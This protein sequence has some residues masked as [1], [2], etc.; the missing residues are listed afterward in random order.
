MIVK[1]IRAMK[2]ET[3]MALAKITDQQLADLINRDRTTILRLRSGKTVAPDW[4]TV[5]AIQDAT[6]GAV[7]PDDWAEAVRLSKSDSENA[8]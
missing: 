7:R 5:L 3:Y 8:A 2:L 6:G 1:H 4:E